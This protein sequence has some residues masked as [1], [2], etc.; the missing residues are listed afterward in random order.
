MS[1]SRAFV[2]EPCKHSLDPVR[3]YGDPVVLF[4]TGDF[5]HSI[6]SP[7]YVNDVLAALKKHRF[8]PARDHFVVAGNI[9]P[10]VRALAG[11]VAAYGQ[12]STLHWVATDR[13]Y[14]PILVG[15]PQH[16]A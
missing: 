16:A 10:I 15:E 11:M 14:T 7:E 4:R 6:W 8:D 9:T 13:V 2:L 12:V 3:D 1:N 5:R